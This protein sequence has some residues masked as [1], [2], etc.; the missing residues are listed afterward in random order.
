MRGK[1]RRFILVHGI[2]GAE[3]SKAEREYDPALDGVELAVGLVGATGN[4]YVKEACREIYAVS[5]AVRR[6]WDEDVPAKLASMKQ[7]LTPRMVTA[8][9]GT[10]W[11]AML[12]VIHCI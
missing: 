1:P 5:V 4:G 3:T 11:K 10:K 9:S 8:S 7:V 2:P 12:D 6:K